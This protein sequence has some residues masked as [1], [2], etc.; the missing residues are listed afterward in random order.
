MYIWQS[1]LRKCVANAP[2]TEIS[3]FR[4]SSLEEKNRLVPLTAAFFAFDLP[5]FISVRQLALILFL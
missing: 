5:F 1:D 4:S 2:L 3:R